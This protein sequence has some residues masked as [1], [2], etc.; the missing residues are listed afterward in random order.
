MEV[1]LSQ[2]IKALTESGL[3]SADETETFIESLPPEKQPEDGAALAKELVR[4]GKLTKFQAQAIYQGKTKLIL[5][6]YVVLDRIGQGGMGQ[7]YKAE[8]RTME[9]VV[10]LKT[11]PASAT[12]SEKAVQRFH[13]EVKVAA[14][15]SHPNI[16]TAHDAGE[17]HGV[18]YLVME[19]VDGSNLASFVRQ[20][21]RLPVD[22]ALDYIIQAARGL[23]FAH[24][25]Q[26]I[27]RDIKPSNLLLDSEGTVKVLDMGLARLNETVRSEEATA[28]ETLTGT[29]QAMGTID[30]MPPEQAE[31]TKAADERSDIYS[32]GCTLFYLLTGRSV[33]GGDTTVQRLLA[34]RDAAVPS[35]RTERPDVPER[36]D[37]LFQNMV[38]KKP[39]DRYGTM[40]EVIVELE[41]CTGQPERVVETT[42]LGN[43]PLSSA[44][45]GTLP[46][47]KT[48][49]TPGDDSLPLELPVIS[50]VDD[51]LLVRPKRAKL[52]RQQI[53]FGAVAAVSLFLVLLL[54]VFL[55]VR[56]PDGTLIVE[57][58]ERDAVVE[59]LDEQGKV[60][61]T[62][63]GEEGKLSISV[64]PGKHRLKVEKDGFK[65]FTRAFEIE[66]GGEQV[67]AARLE[68]LK[69]ETAAVKA[70]EE[71]QPRTTSMAAQPRNDANGTGLIRTLEGHTSNVSSIAFSPDGKI[72][73]S[74]S[75][76]GTVNLWDSAAGELQKRLET[77]LTNFSIAFSPDGARL[78]VAGSGWR[79]HA[80]TRADI[81]EVHRADI[82]EVHLWGVVGNAMQTKLIGHTD[83]VFSVAYSPD[84]SMIASGSWDSTVRLWDARTKDP[85]KTLSG[86]ASAVREIEFAP[87]GQTLASVASAAGE[88][89]LK[90]WNVNSG[91]LLENFPVVGAPD[92][93]AFS[94]DGSTLVLPTLR[95]VELRDTGTFEL[96]GTLSG[97]TDDVRAV[98]FSPD[99]SLVA[100][101]GDDYTVRVWDASTGEL[102][103]TFE[104][105]KDN[106]RSV[107]FSPDGSMLA[108]GS[109]DTTVKI[110]D[111]SALTQP[112]ADDPDRR[113]AEWVLGMK[114][115]VWVS[116]EGKLH[117]NITDAGRLPTVS[118]RVHTLHFPRGRGVRDDDL[119]LIGKLTDL[120]Y[121]LVMSPDV[122]DDGLRH[123]RG[124]A[125][126]THLVLS[127]TGVTDSGLAHLRHLTNLEI[128]ELSGTQITDLGLAD[129]THLKKLR[130]LDLNATKV[131]GKGLRHLHELNNLGL[132]TLGNTGITDNGL[133]ELTS[134]ENL[135]E[136]RLN[137][138]GVS[139][140]GIQHLKTLKNL[141]QLWVGNTKITPEGVADLQAALPNC[142]IILDSDSEESMPDG[143]GAASD[144]DISPATTADSRCRLLETVLRLG[145]QV[146]VWSGNNSTFAVT[147]IGSITQMRWAL[148]SI[149][150]HQS[151][152]PSDKDLQL[153]GHIDYLHRL[154]LTDKSIS[155]TGLMH[156]GHINKLEHLALQNTQVSSEGIGY[157][158]NLSD[159]QSLDLSHNTTVGDASCSHIAK[160]TGLR[161]LDLCST[162]ITDMG[163]RDLSA[164][165][166]LR[167]LELVS[168]KQI[169]AAGLTHLQLLKSLQ[170]LGL[171]DT[172]IS[173]EAVSV[174]ARLRNL[175]LLDLRQTEVTK[176]G[177]TRLKALLPDCTIHHP[178]FPIG[179]EEQQAVRWA[180]EN[181]G[182]MSIY[183]TIQAVE[184]V[185]EETF[186]VYGLEFPRDKSPASGAANLKGM[187]AIQWLNWFGLT[188]A[189]E[190]CEHLGE[191]PSLTAILLEASDLTAVGIERLRGLCQ[192]ESL[193][194]PLAKNID[195]D[196]L[197][198]LAAFQHLSEL[199]VS[200][201]S[202]TDH[203][204]SHL[205][206]LESLRNLTLRFCLNVSG[207][208]LRH[209]SEMP[210]LTRLVLCNTPITDDA[211]P[212]LKAMRG[213]RSL[214]IYF[215]KITAEGAVELQKALP[216]CVVFHESLESIP[217]G[218]ELQDSVA[219]DSESHIS[220][221]AATDLFSLIDVDRDSVEGQWVFQN[222]QL[223]SPPDTEFARIQIP[224]KLP[225]AYDL[226]IRARFEPGEEHAYSFSLVAEGRQFSFALRTKD[227]PEPELTCG[228]SMLDKTKRFFENETTSVT[229]IDQPGRAFDIL[230]SVRKNSCSV[231][232]DGQTRIRWQGSY[233]RL[234]LVE[235]LEVPDSEVLSIALAPTGHCVVEKLLLTQ[236]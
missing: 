9:R 189:D 35:L 112:K 175:R 160:L 190:E 186:A 8:H 83:T 60:E 53:I 235:Y 228:L 193:S 24:K 232:I 46:V 216:D 167:S 163:L 71:A 40:A 117:R 219:K 122:G 223:S 76:D 3:L 21:G 89:V 157:L 28:Q 19:Y 17:S 73:A 97:H 29:G 90:M 111:V 43:I 171:K 6:D 196:A 152:Q 191:L 44:H 102:L 170:V 199:T 215:T 4:Q 104:G 201:A 5:G 195:D 52:T 230:C 229:A 204:L 173:D 77:N 69:G 85:K 234:S 78:A 39:D 51:F 158:A 33:Y 2:F 68:R 136:L 45:V 197:G 184:A 1:I 26:V 108:S 142:K 203:G 178:V 91:E 139:D 159:L 48:E 134:F 140:A 66:S 169:T 127:T 153:L 165:R 207:A 99:G 226:A 172:P 13:R 233:D 137:Q 84:G 182:I 42:D 103:K 96:R 130:R 61:I 119:R 100:S 221:D 128:L 120:R 180:L 227:A 98:D 72:L 86:H 113:A 67:I 64:D 209:L 55:V 80:N 37:V 82:H 222:G 205:A 138:T 126:L 56:T 88:R 143:F 38:A 41:K 109:V 92:S 121:L 22:T 210:K 20:H 217:F 146:Q 213:L 176:E 123:L 211:L 74:A 200:N 101:G 214:D 110:W 58:N 50:P 62:R 32:L 54:G 106:V 141:T 31:N 188:S 118:F 149:V 131:K 59:I 174:L 155:D 187:R 93:I 34:H 145:G 183:G 115:Y 168:C 148:R 70:S 107:A 164:L 144:N 225:Q 25:K 116:A 161:H 75:Y 27:H 206:R 124:L 133:E 147:D 231:T 224:H 185:P 129:L 220:P 194:L 14:R 154:N 16:V 65:L 87:D 202:I 212:H 12:K 156:L 208:G 95:S 23:E 151:Q 181:G 125:G 79:G 81:H 10:A 36:V 94:P 236:K 11:L 177:A 132:L 166:S 15:L 30:F 218:A 150:L 192:L 63:N 7:V 179:L 135:T 162:S 49:E 57:I 198:N 114:G 105:H 47:I 18:H